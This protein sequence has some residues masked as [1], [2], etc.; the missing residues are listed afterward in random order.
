MKPFPVFY[1]TAVRDLSTN[2]GLHPTSDA[3]TETSSTVA[4]PRLS[5]GEIEEVWRASRQ[6][7]LNGVI[8][9]PPM[10]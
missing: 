3:Q 1:Q 9:V 7:W 4:A 2:D 6:C 8:G 5:T 10:R